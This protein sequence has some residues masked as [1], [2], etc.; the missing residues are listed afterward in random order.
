MIGKTSIAK[1]PQTVIKSD[2]TL[3]FK[4]VIIPPTAFRAAN[5]KNKI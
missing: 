2:F 5:I 3:K 1:M 4:F